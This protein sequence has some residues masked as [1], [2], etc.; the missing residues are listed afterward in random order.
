MFRSFTGQVCDATTARSFPGSS[1]HRSGRTATATRENNAER[2]G[3]DQ[4]PAA[5][6]DARGQPVSF[7]DPIGDRLCRVVISS[8]VSAK[9]INFPFEVVSAGFPR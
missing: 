5:F 9:R 3:T 6:G 4:F 8:H 2:R 1:Y 7:G